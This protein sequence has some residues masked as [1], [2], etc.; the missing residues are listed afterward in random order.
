MLIKVQLENFPKFS[1]SLEFMQ[2]LANDRNVFVFPSECFYFPGFIRIILVPPEEILKETCDRIL[3]FCSKYYM[4]F[5]G[6]L[7]YIEM[8]KK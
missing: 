6:L 2:K 8:N 4:P 5:D 7:H 1:S 3:E